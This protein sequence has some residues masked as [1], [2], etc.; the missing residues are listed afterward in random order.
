MKHPIPRALALIAVP[1]VVGAAV[2]AAVAAAGPAAASG[3]TIDAHYGLYWG[4]MMVADGKMKADLRPGSY[5]LTT[6]NQSRG[7]LDALVTFEINAQVEG[8]M[9]KDRPRPTLYGNR[10]AWNSNL[11]SIEMVYP[12]GGLV[13]VNANPPTGEDGHDPVPDHLRAG[14]IDPMTASLGAMASSTAAEPCRWESAVFDGRRRT[15]MRFEPIGPESLK[16]NPALEFDGAAVKCK[17]V[18]ERV[19]GLHKDE[20]RATGPRPPS[21][22]WVAKYARGNIWLPVKVEFPSRWGA[23][24]G[25]MLSVSTT[26]AK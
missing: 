19:A 16:P 7:V 6:T 13:N 5:T 18:N 3:R 11:R 22:V 25:E 8:R 4:G 23:V 21:F 26:P 14:T 2:A 15:N 20:K 24:T 1:A 12:Q 17:F 9:D 10:S